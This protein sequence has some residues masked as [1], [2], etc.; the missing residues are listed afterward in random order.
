MIE[1]IVARMLPLN[2]DNANQALGRSKD[3]RA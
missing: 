2:Y 3:K 1:E